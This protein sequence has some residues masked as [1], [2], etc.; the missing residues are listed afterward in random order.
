M[1]Q[2]I[3]RDSKEAQHLMKTNDQYKQQSNQ[4]QRQIHKG[5]AYQNIGKSILGNF[6]SIANLKDKM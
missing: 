4:I 5:L 2:A 6:Q 3:M 1:L